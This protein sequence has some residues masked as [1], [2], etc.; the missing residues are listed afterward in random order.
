VSEKVQYGHIRDGAYSACCAAGVALAL[1]RALAGH[2]LDGETDHYVARNPK[3]VGP[4]C[5]AVHAAYGP[6][7]DSRRAIKVGRP[8]K[9]P[10]APVAASRKGQRAA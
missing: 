3:M 2:Q 8:K 5:N 10:A 6:I 7:P 9:V 4:A 1:C